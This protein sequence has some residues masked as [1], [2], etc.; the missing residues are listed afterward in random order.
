[1][2]IN[3]LA[4][5]HCSKWPVIIIGLK[6]AYLKDETLQLFIH[7]ANMTAYL[8]SQVLKEQW[9]NQGAQ[10]CYDIA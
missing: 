10:N 1:M 8:Y 2:Y 9:Q 6:G 3:Q 7:S 4:N 5:I